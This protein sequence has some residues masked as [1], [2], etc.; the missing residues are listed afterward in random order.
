MEKMFAVE[1]TLFVFGVDKLTVDDV[2]MFFSKYGEVLHVIKQKRER[3]FGKNKVCFVH[4][5]S[6]SQCKAA[7]EAG[8]EIIGSTR[9]KHYI[10]KCSLAVDIGVNP[11]HKTEEQTPVFIYMKNLFSKPLISTLT[12]YSFSFLT[13]FGK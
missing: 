7:F 3:R 4:Y 10:G 12:C 13:S 5:R 6:A 11:N 9:R 1:A 2:K 8:Q